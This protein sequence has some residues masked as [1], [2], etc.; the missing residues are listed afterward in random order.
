MYREYVQEV[1]SRL[2]GT[3][4]PAH[5][6]YKTSKFIGDELEEIGYRVYRNVGDS[7]GIIGELD[8]GRP[9]PILGIRADMD[10][11]SY[12]I[13]GEIEYRHTCGHDAHSSMVLATAK[14]IY[15]LGISKGKLY[16]IFQ[17]AEEVLAGAKLMINSGLINDLTEI[18]GIHLRP[19]EEC[20]Y[21][22]ASAALWHS[23]SGPTKIKLK[24]LQSHGARPHLGV[25]A[26][27][28][29]VLVTNAINAIKANPKISHSIKVTNINSGQGAS[30]TIPD[31]AYM[32]VDVRCSDNDEMKTIIEKLKRVIELTAKANGAQVEYTINFCPGADYDEELINTN[33][34]IISDILGEENLIRDLDTAG[35]E[36]FHFYKMELG[37]KAAYLGLGADLRPG[38]HHKDMTFNKE[39]LYIGVDILVNLIKKRLV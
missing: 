25:N 34:D 2:H 31:E 29:A 5:K 11:L 7:T 6:E 36:D 10:A 33:A 3:P 18:V 22:Q 4:E 12:E 13:N 21:G 19:I 32:S 17:P 38:L 27:E 23:A 37:C 35:S 24:G 1:F 9:G 26:V 20:K 30:N 15:S 8:S 14:E 28:A 39:A 16:F